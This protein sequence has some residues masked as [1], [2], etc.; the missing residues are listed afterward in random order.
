ME[1]IVQF[2]GIVAV[3]V[4][5]LATLL[6]GGVHGI[7]LSRR[8]VK[9]SG[10]RQVGVKRTSARGG[11]KTSRPRHRKGPGKAIGLQDTPPEGRSILSAPNSSP[12]VSACPSCG[13]VAPDEL[14]VEHFSGS[15]SHEKGKAPGE[16]LEEILEAEPNTPDQSSETIVTMRHIIQMLIPPRAFG[17][18]HLE[19][20][21]NPL[22]EIVHR[23]ET[24]RKTPV[25][26]LASEVKFLESSQE[27][28]AQTVPDSGAP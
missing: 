16:P 4:G 19:K 15:P 5:W 20:T 25:E 26:T 22:S 24:A 10:A 21:E 18:R 28:L 9:K 2:L 27:A 12:A 7:R 3:T 1:A 23:L 11:R 13:L 6:A 14:M 17:R 8:I